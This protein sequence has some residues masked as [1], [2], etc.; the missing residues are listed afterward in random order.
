[1][2]PFGLPVRSR[3]YKE[4]RLVSNHALRF[5]SRAVISSRVGML[6]RRTIP[7]S[8]ASKP[9]ASALNL[10]DTDTADLAVDFA[11]PVPPRYSG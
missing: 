5:F 3:L 4:S 11:S 9:N 6:L 2:V 1:M 8:G 7:S 10:R